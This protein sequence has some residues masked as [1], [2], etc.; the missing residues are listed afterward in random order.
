MNLGEAIKQIRKERGLSLDD[1]AD[2]CGISTP[3]ISRIE[4]GKQWPSQ[5]VLES[6]AKEL[7]V[8]IYQLFVIAEGVSLP[9][10]C[11]SESER[12]FRGVMQGLDAQDRYMVEA[13]AARLAAKK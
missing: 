6:I 8:Y 11:E 7:D 5:A 12:A 13:M 10:P 1:L 4:T 3:S 2:L 9:R